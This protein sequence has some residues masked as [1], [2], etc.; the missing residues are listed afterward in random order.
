MLDFLRL[1]VEESQKEDG[2]FKVDKVLPSLLF[3]VCSKIVEK[4]KEM[5]LI[6]LRQSAKQRN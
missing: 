5:S 1:C 3:S 2:T 6:M 4:V